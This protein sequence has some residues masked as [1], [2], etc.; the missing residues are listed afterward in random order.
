MQNNLLLCRCLFI[1]LTLACV[2]YVF[3]MLPQVYQLEQIVLE[4]KPQ[5][6]GVKQ[7]YSSQ[8]S[9]KHIAINETSEGIK[10]SDVSTA[11]KL[12]VKY[13]GQTV[14]AS[15]LVIVEPITLVFDDSLIGIEPKSGGL[16]IQHDGIRYFYDNTGL[17]L[18]GE[19]QKG[20][21]YCRDLPYLSGEIESSL[22]DVLLKLRTNAMSRL[23]IGGDLLCK[24]RLPVSGS[25]NVSAFINI[26]EQDFVLH[27]SRPES[28]FIQQKDGEWESLSS[29]AIN[30]SGEFIAG[31]THYNI[32]KA[33]VGKPSYVVKV[34]SK[35]PQRKLPSFVET[36]TW[37][38]VF[39]QPLAIKQLPKALWL[40]SSF[41][42]FCA[43]TW[44]KLYRFR[45][46]QVANLRLYFWCVLGLGVVFADQMNA[47]HL[48]IEWLL[49]LFTLSAGVI[50]VRSWHLVLFFLV[51]AGSILQLIL[52]LN[53]PVDTLLIKAREQVVILSVFC[54]VTGYLQSLELDYYQGFLTAMKSK[55]WQWVMTKYVLFFAY[56]LLL[57]N[58]FFSGSE[59]GIPNFINP[60]EV[61]KLVMAFV[62]AIFISNIFLY[63]NSGILA[64][65][66]KLVG[67]GLAF[68]IF[69]LLFLASIKDFSPVII[70]SGMLLAI[71]VVL[72]LIFL[73][74]DS[75]KS[76]I[77][78]YLMIVFVCSGLLANY[79]WFDNKIEQ[80]T[81]DTYHFSLPAVDRWK[82]LKLPEENYINAYQ[83]TESKRVQ[84]S[85]ELS[86]VNNWHKMVA[87]P[88]IQDDL[89]LTHLIVRTG[90][91][92][93]TI[94]IGVFI[95]LVSYF[96]L[97]SCRII[98]QSI[99]SAG[100]LLVRQQ[101]VQL[102]IFCVLMSAA[103]FT[104][105]IINI[106]SNIGAIPLMGQPMA[107][108][109]I[110]NSHLIAFVMPTIIAFAFLQNQQSRI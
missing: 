92:F 81:I 103:L 6:V 66:F 109:S 105:I 15:G 7:L 38:P 50:V 20:L 90:W 42:L 102:A 44:K 32:R 31:R 58:Q 100:L 36:E 85:E 19:L 25:P 12:L 62:A 14:N 54:L 91:V 94:Y 101:V 73:T 37:I 59:T 83:I 27:S 17:S 22:I 96:F 3:Y 108:I 45:S 97:T 107:F 71:V 16:E 52:G 68:I 61:I 84:A 55:K 41:M 86:G 34:D 5:T 89:S 63:H 47:I 48:P 24:S 110:A 49:A 1:L 76:R 87:V 75:I 77:I 51:L 21:Q 99:K 79:V 106:G 46:Y 39:G 28:I 10:L 78:G 57:L 53:A 33:I 65:L 9:D 56:C 18:V 69:A 35:K 29:Y 8:M 95:G 74:R 11:R 104:H 30:T 2:S 40:I 67:A 23:S 82:S 4:V 70:L 13:K 88:A 64:Q 60:T 72:I 26:V 93:S 80:L 98:L 43:V